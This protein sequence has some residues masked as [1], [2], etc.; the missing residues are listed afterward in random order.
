MSTPVRKSASDAAFRALVQYSK[1]P[2]GHKTFQVADDGSAPH[3]V[4]SEFAVIDTTDRKPQHG[5]LY[6]I[7]Y[8]SGRR[9]RRIVHVRSTMSQITPPPSPKQQV[10][11]TGDLAGFRRVGNVS[12][13]GGGIPEFTGL[14]DGPYLAAHLSAKLI[15][16]VVGFAA[17][18][19]GDL[20]AASL[21]YE[22][23]ALHNAAFDP[24]E[25]LDVLIGTGYRPCVFQTSDG[26]WVYSEYM[27]E[28]GNTDAEYET[29]MAVRWKFVHA[30]SAKQRVTDECVRRGLVEA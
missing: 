25:Y 11:W 8:E 5:E 12:G 4:E 10:W 27:P 20:L 7:Q 18:A 17:T 21:G 15:G 24:V 6:L 16:R 9:N 28:R 26:R 19:L 13:K 2:R 14:S 1:L 3:L 29:I 23:E 30:S 22:D